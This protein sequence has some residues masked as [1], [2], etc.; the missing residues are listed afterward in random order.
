MNRTLAHRT[1]LLVGVALLGLAA[2]RMAMADNLLKPILPDVSAYVADPEAALVLGKALFFDEQVGS[3]GAACAS[4]HFSAGADSRIQNQLSPGLKDITIGEN[5]DATFGSQ[6]S[7]TSAVALGEMPSRAKAAANYTLTPDDLPLH[8]LVDERDRNSAIVTTTNDRVSS[9]GSFA[10]QFLDVPQGNERDDECEALSDPTFYTQ[11]EPPAGIRLPTR[12]VEPRNTPTT[13]NAVFLQRNFWDS[14]ANSLFNGVGV[15]GMRDIKG[16]PTKRLIVEDGDGLKLTWLEIENASLASQAVGPPTSHL[17]MSCAGRVFPEIGRKMIGRRPLALQ[18][19]DPTDSTLGRFARQDGNGLEVEDYERLIKQAFRPEYWAAAGRWRIIETGPDSSAL[20][21]DP[22]GYTQM[23]QNFSMFWGISIMLYEQTL[24]SDQSEFD[25]KAGDL[26]AAPIF[27]ASD[28]NTCAATQLGQEDPLWLRGC[29][30]FFTGDGGGFSKPGNGDGANCA[31]CHRTDVPGSGSPPVQGMLSEAAQ[32]QGAPL[33]I[34]VDVVKQ[35]SFGGAVDPTSNFLHRRDAGFASVGLRPP[36]TDLLI[37]ATDDYGNPLSFARQYQSYLDHGGAFAAGSSA[38]TPLDPA[39]QDALSTYILD[40]VLERSI[41][42]WLKTPPGEAAF[43]PSAAPLEGFPGNGAP[44]SVATQISIGVDGAAKA[45]ILRNVALT[46]PYFSW[47]GYPDLRQVVKF[48]NRGGNRRDI[49]GIEAEAAGVSCTTGD[50]MGTGPLGNTPL[51]QIEDGGG[52]E[53]NCDTNVA[54]AVKVL[55]LLDCDPGFQGMPGDH[56]PRCA[57]QNKTA[58]TDDLA[59]LVRFMK[60]LSD[61]RVQCNQAPFDGPE[62]HILNGHRAEDEDH[63][64]LADDIVAVIPA[65]GQ[66]GFKDPKLCI[67]NAGDIFAAGMRGRLE[68]DPR[69][70]SCN[71]DCNGNGVVAVTD[72]IAAVNIALGRAP[73]SRCLTADVNRDEAL[74]INELLAAVNE[75]LSGCGSDLAR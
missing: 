67:P 22:N 56:D 33:A 23:E 46:P 63:D 43:D 31:V 18:D 27:P 57:A 30:L 3:D 51:A 75:L 50:N 9:A 68:Y 12:Q 8:R 54:Q 32:L 6:R 16:D 38:N 52:I 72:L 41:V 42:N 65:S 49:G 2:N 60:S 66:G 64:G 40:P 73:L 4:C 71:G 7:D 44:A 34:F 45:P 19:V 17:E 61:P 14:R 11:A 53:T 15:F 24:I 10:S 47:G 1:P 55:N 69:S 25:T 26:R 39:T 58:E 48:Y 36:F 13:I 28:F 59:A 29:Q 37:G 62:L 21:D 35:Q 20:Q 5:G 74:A 70:A